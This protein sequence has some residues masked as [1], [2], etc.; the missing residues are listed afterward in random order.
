MTSFWVGVASRDHVLVGVKG[1]F[2]QLGHGK[3]APLQR[4]KPGDRIV[5]YSPREQMGDGAALQAFTAAGEVLE[6][7]LEQVDMGGGFKPYR[8]KVRFFKASEAPIRPLLPQLSFTRGVSSW[9]Y[10]FRRGAFRIEPEDY[11]LIARA[12]GVADDAAG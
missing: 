10:A 12:M 8:R 2:C 6:G 7:K 11:R 3:A 5:F 1:G 4:L 9:G